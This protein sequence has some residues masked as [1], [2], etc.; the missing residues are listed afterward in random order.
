MT[1]KAEGLPA[2]VS[3]LLRSRS[4]G[5]TSC[6]QLLAAKLDLYGSPYDVAERNHRMYFQRGAVAFGFSPGF[7]RLLERGR[8]AGADG[9]GISRPVQGGARL[10]GA[11]SAR[12]MASV[13]GAGSG[14]W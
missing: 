7:T 11:C 5:F 9:P 10:V 8:S 2:S 14:G 13:W 1:T 3:I 6:D 12:R 4:S